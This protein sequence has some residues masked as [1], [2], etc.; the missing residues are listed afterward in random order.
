MQCDWKYEEETQK[1]KCINCGFRV[2]RASMKHRCSAGESPIGVLQPPSLR[3]KAANFSKAITKHVLSGRKHTSDAERAKRLSIC[4]DNKCGLF[5]QNNKNSDVGVCSH[6]SCG[7]F[8]RDK[9]KFLDKLSWAD[10]ECPVGLWAKTP[11]NPENG[12]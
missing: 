1:F 5:K 3:R 7:C 11:E 12:V 8:L 10:S 6:Q 9:G 2:P 4:K